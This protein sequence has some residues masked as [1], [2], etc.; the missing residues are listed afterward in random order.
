M[1]NL[2]KDGVTMSV[3]EKIKSAVD[4]K[5]L[6]IEELKSLFDVIRLIQLIRTELH[7]RDLS[8]TQLTVIYKLPSIFNIIF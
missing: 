2:S 4:V 6:N 7:L 1:G 5:K 3:L 8:K